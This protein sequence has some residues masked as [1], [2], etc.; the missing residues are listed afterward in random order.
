MLR[1]KAYK[2]EVQQGQRAAKSGEATGGKAGVCYTLV[3]EGYN[4]TLHGLV[5]FC[6][7]LYYMK[8]P[9]EDLERV[10]S[11]GPFRQ[12]WALGR[13]ASTWTFVDPGWWIIVPWISTTSDG[14][15]SAFPSEFRGK[16]IKYALRVFTENVT[17]IEELNQAPKYEHQRPMA[18]DQIQHLVDQL[19]LLGGLGDLRGLLQAAGMDLGSL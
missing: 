6:A 16:P 2:F 15:G 14:E 7:D 8:A 4:S 19:R 11:R 12:T 10:Y 17:K 9:D 3:L 13:E 18:P 1:F 5:K